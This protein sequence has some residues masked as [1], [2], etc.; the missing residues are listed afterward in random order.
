LQ[1]VSTWKIKLELQK[2]Y[3]GRIA[4]QDKKQSN[5]KP[6]YIKKEKLPT[7]EKKLFFEIRNERVRSCIICGKNI[8]EAKTRCFA[9]I[10]P[11]WQRPKYRL[12]KNNIVLVCSIDCHHKVDS[13]IVGKKKL[14]EDQLLS[15]IIPNIKWL[16]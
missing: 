9:H 6:K 13:M 1:F 12:H 2:S 11:K 16:I 8:K 15:W 3:S 10:L 14:V 4:H 7:G 5:L